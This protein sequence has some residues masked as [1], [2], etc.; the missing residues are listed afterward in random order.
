MKKEV[1]IE[2]FLFLLAVVILF[3]FT[4]SL[5]YA[6]IC[7]CDSC[8]SCK[9]ALNN[10]SCTEVRLTANI[11][12]FA[13][14]CIDNPENF[15]NKIFDCQGNTIDGVGNGY[16][17][18][19]DNKQNNTIKNCIITDFQ[20]GIYLK[21][22]SSNNTLTNNTASSNSYGI[23]L[24]SSSNNTLTNNTANSNIQSGIYLSSSSNNTLI[25]NTA[26]SN[27]NYHGIY[28][29]NSSNNNNLINNTINLN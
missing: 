26:N 22:S 15:N 8:G 24:D 12:N 1:K 6:E 16:G 11:T 3:I 9:N 4:S 18:Y 27:V 21:S 2:F 28:L 10:A 7:E 5:I 13:G 20:F 17:I 25:N 23:Y 14:T 29:Y 19:L